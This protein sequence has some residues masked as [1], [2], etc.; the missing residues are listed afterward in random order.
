[1]DTK[2]LV[3]QYLANGGKIK[4]LPAGEAEGAL[5]LRGKDSMPTKYAPRTRTGWEM[6][7]GTEEF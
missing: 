7:Y 1:M 5:K 4:K 6:D 3:A 2:E